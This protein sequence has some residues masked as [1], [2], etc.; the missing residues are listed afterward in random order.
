M[1]LVKNNPWETLS[2]GKVLRVNELFKHDIYWGKDD[3]ERCALLFKLKNKLE[4]I[5]KVILRGIDFKYDALTNQ[6]GFILKKND[7]WEIFK[8]L[9]DDLIFISKS[10]VKEKMMIEKIVKRLIEWKTLLD[11]YE[12]RELSLEEQMGLFTELKT[13]KEIIIPRLGLVQGIESWTGPEGDYQDFLCI[14]SAIE[15]KSCITSKG[16]TATI[17]NSNQ[18]V[19]SKENLYLIHYTLTPFEKGESVLTYIQSISQSI[20]DEKIENKFLIKLSNFIGLSTEHENLY[21]FKVDD[22]KIYIVSDMFPRIN[23][24][25]LDKRIKNIKYSIDLDQCKD[26]ETT[27]LEV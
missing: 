1:I 11:K 19:T 17:S 10:E 3:I 15:V 21:K 20:L 27:E 14:N 13:L 24:T 7:N 8:I 5:P 26:F 23:V 6:M 22:Y 4:R 18:L 25:L 9:C 2:K 12:R 16:R